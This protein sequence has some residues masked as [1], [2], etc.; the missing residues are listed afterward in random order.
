MI[1]RQGNITQDYL[2]NSENKLF[3]DNSMSPVNFTGRLSQVELK[4]KARTN[5]NFMKSR[6]E[7]SQCKSRIT[8]DQN[9]LIP[10]KCIEESYTNKSSDNNSPDN[11]YFEKVIS[12]EKKLGKNKFKLNFGWKNLKFN[13]KKREKFE[14]IKLRSLSRSNFVLGEV[15]SKELGEYSFE[16]KKDVKVTRKVNN[17]KVVFQNTIQCKSSSKDNDYPIHVKRIQRKHR[18]ISSLSKQQYVKFK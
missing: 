12:P 13:R 11:N 5:F 8:A 14:N 4:K 3:S 10:L 16:D 1:I 7:S 6:A 17:H 9:I 2:S 18:S 15:K